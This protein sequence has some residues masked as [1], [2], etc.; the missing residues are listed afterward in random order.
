MVF[1]LKKISNHGTGNPIVARLTI[2]LI[3]LLKFS[4]LGKEKEDA[5]GTDFMALHQ[6][7]LRCFVIL[8]QLEENLAKSKQECDENS[9]I[10]K[11]PRVRQVPFVPQLEQLAENFLYESKN[12]LRDLAFIIGKFH[13]EKFNEASNFC[14]LKDPTKLSLVQAWFKSKYGDKEWIVAVLQADKSW[15]YEIMSKRNASEHPGGYSGVLK[16]INVALDANQEV[17]APAWHR[18]NYPPTSIFNDMRTCIENLLSFAEDMIIF[19]CIT[20]KLPIAISI[21][22][23]PESK[24]RPENPVRFYAGSDPEGKTFYFDKAS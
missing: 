14:N 18:G 11:D 9:K 16:I 2:Q 12:F 10:Q 17:I 4:F 15:L 20:K 24:R 7:L 6:R 19:G 23:L 8:T 3:D 22:D 1:Q 13:N 5:L 21:V